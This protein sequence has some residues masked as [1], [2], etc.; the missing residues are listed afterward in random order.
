MMSIAKSRWEK[1]LGELL[2]LV[3][4]FVAA[5]AWT[6]AAEPDSATLVRDIM[7][8]TGVD[9]GV[10]SMLGVDARAVLPLIRSKRFFVHILHPDADV[11][12]RLRSVADQLGFGIDRV[13]IEQME[14]TQLPYAD[15]MI[16]L[17]LLPSGTAE[18][19]DQIPIA[20]VLRVLRPEGIAIV[21]ELGAQDPANIDDLLKRWSGSRPDALYK[22]VTNNVIVLRKPAAKDTD[23]WPLW[24]HGPDNN[25]ITTDQV[26]K[27]PYL[28]QF[29]ADPMYITMPA[30]TTIAGGRTFLATGNIAHHRREWPW[31]NQLI[32][33]NGYNG[34]ILWQ[35]SL[36]DGFLAHRSAYV[37]TEK[38][39]YL[40]NGNGCLQLDA[41]TGDDRGR[42]TI[43]GVDG[44]W[45]W[46]VLDNGIMFVMSGPHDGLA[47]IV[48]GDRTYGG[49]SWADLSPGYYSRPHVPWGFGHVLTAY[50]M[51]QQKVLWRHEETALVDSRA[52][53]MCGGKLLV[54][55]PDKYF[56]CLDTKTGQVL[57]T[58]DQADVRKLVEQPGRGL[59]STPGFRSECMALATPEV[60]VIQGQT[61]MNVVALSSQ[62]GKLLWTKKKFT[63]NPN[64][65]YIDGH[66]VLGVGPRG[67]HVALEPLTGDVIEDYQFR[68][69]SCTRLTGCPDSLFVRGEGTLRFDRAKRRS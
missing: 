58:N 64:A 56:R 14:P 17:L 30:I 55:C 29:M 12:K 48:K 44:D 2:L 60:F 50:D 11:V 8:Q 13:L 66:V 35:R 1:M 10:C 23:D 26:I 24:Q 51:A 15:N 28:T 34:S 18:Q 5:P 9:R 6:I 65:I 7:R 61:R 59:V 63:N 47:Q 32:A 38:T 31:I 40:M 43:P 33:R 16:D 45:K 19:L 27:A 37:A 69:V 21:G 57:W 36:P 42:F 20:E 53:A 46:M 67:S 25:P 68:K 49:W 39:F 4:L 22:S 3:L 41:A 54:Y 62:D 52:L